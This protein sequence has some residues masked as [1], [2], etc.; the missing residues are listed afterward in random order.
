MYYCCILTNRSTVTT[1]PVATPI[2]FTTQEPVRAREPITTWIP[3][4]AGE[5]ITTQEP[6]RTRGP[7]TTQEP[8]IDHTR[9]STENTQGKSERSK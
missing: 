8:E 3:I 4:R 6:M 1:E 7:R 9:L 2:P 5:P